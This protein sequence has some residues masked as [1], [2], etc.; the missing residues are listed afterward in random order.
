MNLV[1]MDCNDENEICCFL[2]SISY[3]VAHLPSC[4][5][6]T[7]VNHL[8]SI[9][10]L[11]FLSGKITVKIRKFKRKLTCSSKRSILQ[12]SHYRSSVFKLCQRIFEQFFRLSV[13][14]CTPQNRSRVGGRCAVDLEVFKFI[15]SNIPEINFP[16]I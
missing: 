15:N 5:K 7:L 11:L 12:V 14:S 16:Y 2:K 10:I 1:N 9:R 6:A 8:F 4:R 13:K 3:T